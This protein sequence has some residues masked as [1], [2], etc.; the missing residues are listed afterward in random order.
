MTF[1]VKPKF[2]SLYSMYMPANPAPTITTS[3]LRVLDPFP[4]ACAIINPRDLVD[5]AVL[6]SPSLPS[7]RR[8]W[9]AAAGPAYRSPVRRASSTPDPEFADH[10]LPSRP[11]R[12]TSTG[13]LGVPIAQFPRTG[14]RKDGG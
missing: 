2:R 7:P 10:A 8:T 5:C 9:T 1:A 4:C 12:D 3:R 13:F 14:T 11:G 6:S